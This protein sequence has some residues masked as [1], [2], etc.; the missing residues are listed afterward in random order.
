MTKSYASRKRGMAP[1]T[2]VQQLSMTI[3][4]G[5]FVSI[6]GPSGCGKTTILHMVA[7]FE[8]PSTGRVLLDGKEVRGSSADR[9]V[10]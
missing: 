5:E 2:A 8:I 6:V 9:T 3:E 7:G 10:V 1:T 4:D